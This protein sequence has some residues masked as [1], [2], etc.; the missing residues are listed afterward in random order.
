MGILSP[1]AK[2][3]NSATLNPLFLC[4]LSE[5]VAGEIPAIS[6]ALRCEIPALASSIRM[7]C[8]TISIQ[9]MKITLSSQGVQCNDNVS[10]CR[11]LIVFLLSLFVI[12][13]TL[14]L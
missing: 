6:A 14:N 12:S 10:V 4:I 11:T 7:F 1:L 9:V 2:A 8:R 5:N 3:T 13:A